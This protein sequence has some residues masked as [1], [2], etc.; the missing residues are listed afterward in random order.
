[1]KDILKKKVSWCAIK[2]IPKNIIIGIG[3]GSTV[4]Y[5]IE[6]LST[7]RSCIFGAVASSIESRKILLKFNIPVIN[8]ND[9]K[10]SYI[11]IY[12]DSADEIN[13][14]MEMI[15]GGGGALTQEKIIA[16][17]SKKFLCI[18]DESKYVK[19]LGFNCPLPIEIIPMSLKYVSQEI[20]KL[21]GIPKYRKNFVT[22]NGNYIIDVYKLIINDTNYL[23]KFINNIP[24]VVCVGLFSFRKAD[25]LLISSNEGVQ[26]IV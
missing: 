7:I 22:D 6:A 15:K 18:I 13:K 17:A 21:G 3:S 14:N 25:I 19:N 16:S 26:E 23:E 2:Y 1:M 5:F 10:C 8:L 20:F 24:G 12:V 4:K 11:D 9:M